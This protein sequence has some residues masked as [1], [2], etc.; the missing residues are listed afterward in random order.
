MYALDEQAKLVRKG[1]LAWTCRHCG[2][3]FGAEF[4][5]DKHMDKHLIDNAQS[6]STENRACLEDYCV[7][8]DVCDRPVNRRMPL[9]IESL[10]V[11]Q[12]HSLKMSI[13]NKKSV[14]DVGLKPPELKFSCDEEKLAV[15]FELCRSTLSLCFPLEGLH[16]GDGVRL[17]HMELLNGVCYALQSC[18]SYMSRRKY[19]GSPKF[20]KE[21]SFLS[22]VE[23]SV[24]RSGAGAKAGWVLFGVFGALLTGSVVGY[25]IVKWLSGDDGFLFNKSYRGKSKK[26]K[27]LRGM[28]ASARMEVPEGFR[29]LRELADDL[30][31]RQRIK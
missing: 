18:S 14:S 15:A 19:R 22:A 10:S 9:L 28:N 29:T 27:A 21:E 8:F 31:H 12:D 26:G 30:T 23:D 5:I 2:A 24:N 1:P 7:I 17:V 11:V 4:D 13:D 25:L 6:N 20:F 16:V 3:T